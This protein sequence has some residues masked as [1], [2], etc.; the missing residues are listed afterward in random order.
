MNQIEFAK[1]LIEEYK[2]IY[3]DLLK[4]KAT[5]NIMFLQCRKL[6]MEIDP[7]LAEQLI[8]WCDMKGHD[9]YRME[10]GSLC[11][12]CIAQSEENE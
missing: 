9:W 6:R 5:I 3:V 10:D 4:Q 12:R 1:G 2:G 7:L 11:F 8:K